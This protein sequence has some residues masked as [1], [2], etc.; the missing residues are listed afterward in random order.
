MY[1]SLYRINKWFDNIPD[2]KRFLCFLGF[3]FPGIFAMGALELNIW[4]G[5]FGLTYM[6]LLIAMRHYYFKGTFTPK[7]KGK[8]NG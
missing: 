6:L 8:M 2:P 1:Q 3:A 5:M 4:V 7:I